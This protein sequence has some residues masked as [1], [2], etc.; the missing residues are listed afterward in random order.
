VQDVNCD[1]AGHN[2]CASTCAL[3]IAPGSIA[4]SI[5]GR[6][7]W[8]D[9]S[10]TSGWE[11][12]WITAYSD[13]SFSTHCYTWSSP[14]AGVDHD[15]FLISFLR[16]L[17]PSAITGLLLHAAPTPGPVSSNPGKD[18]LPKPFLPSFEQVSA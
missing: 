17:L 18:P 7:L 12:A 15:I 9:Q 14:R 5:P 16:S 4:Q 13:P 2:K 6:E 11:T 3:Y 10:H 1:E 8:Q